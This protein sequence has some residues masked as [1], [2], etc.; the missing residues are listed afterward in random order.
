M[1]NV[2]TGLAVVLGWY[3]QVGRQTE[4]SHPP[5]D[6]FTIQIRE[7]T[8]Q[9]RDIYVAP[10]DDGLWQGALRDPAAGIFK[11]VSAA[12]V[13]GDDLRSAGCTAISKAGSA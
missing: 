2:G 7:S 6:E 13:A 9:I 12:I 5:L 4:R 8:I 11:S 10:A 1:R 3:I